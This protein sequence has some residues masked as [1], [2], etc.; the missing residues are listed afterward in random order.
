MEGQTT[1]GVM[2][3]YEYHPY[4]CFDE[5]KTGSD[6]YI[7]IDDSV[8]WTDAQTYCRQ[9][10]T[11]LASAKDEN[12]NSLIQSIIS[13]RTWI[14]LI[15]DGWKWVDQTN[16]SYVTWIS[17]EPNNYWENEN[18]GYLEMGEAGDSQCS[19]IMPFFCYAATAKTQTVR[20]KIQSN[21]DLNDPAVNEDILEKIKQKL[22]D[23]GMEEDVTVKWIIKPDRVVFHKEKGNF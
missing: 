7:Y 17:G 6:R 14:G 13:G 15:K 5:T 3:C 11:D 18:C 2:E 19:D 4:I 12:E 9:Y 23:H 22:K 8:E 1:D 10:Y 20:M 21:Q 16:F